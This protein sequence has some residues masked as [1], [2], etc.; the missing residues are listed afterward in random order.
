M[1]RLTTEKAL[2]LLRDAMP[3]PQGSDGPRADLWPC[4][5]RRIDRGTSPPPAA[6]WVLA[7]TLAMLCL[8]RP[9]L[10]G[11]LLLHF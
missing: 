1:T 5:R 11:V 7:V 6:D 8:L 3:A 10:V 9:S 4:V 2:E